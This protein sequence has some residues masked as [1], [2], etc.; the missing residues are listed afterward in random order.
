MVVAVPAVGVTVLEFAGSG[1][2]HTVDGD[3]KIQALTSQWV[4]GIDHHEVVVNLNNRDRDRALGRATVELHA[5]R[6]VRH[7][8]ECFARHLLNRSHIVLAIRFG[9]YINGSLPAELS[10]TSPASLVSV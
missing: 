3:V 4:I 9:R 6:E 7:S 10:R 8:G 1:V 5:D 2:A